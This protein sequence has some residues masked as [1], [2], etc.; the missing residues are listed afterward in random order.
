MRK[1]SLK[2]FQVCFTILLFSEHN[3]IG[4]SDSLSSASPDTSGLPV[5]KSVH[6]MY[7]GAGYG[8]N[9]VYLG[10]TISG[11]QPYG[12]AA[13]SYGFKNSIYVTASAMHLSDLDPFATI[14]TGTLSYSHTFN[15]WFDISLSGSRYQVP[16][17]LEASLFKSFFYG[18]ITLGLDWRLLYTKISA[19]YL[20]MNEGNMYYQLRNSRYFVTP[21]FFKKKVNISF[22]PYI[23]VLFGTLS[24][25]EL[26]TAIIT[27]N[28]PFY[29]STGNSG[30]GNGSV[31]G[32]GPGA[33]AG[34]SAATGTTATSTQTITNT[35]ISK[36][37]SAMEIDFGLPVALNTERLTIEAEPGYILPLFDDSGFHGTKGFVFMLNCYFKIF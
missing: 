28:Y 21:S 6:S 12:F 29:N 3:I 13:L 36:K 37:F 26:D 15:S 24:E 22:D 33:G 1:G 5:K 31:N 2:I 10:S 16:T 9:M 8:S 4:Q 7:A 32:N 18:D 27:V 14:I 19:G 11:D 17:S 34:T 35:L 30:N 25:I 23:N 20:Y